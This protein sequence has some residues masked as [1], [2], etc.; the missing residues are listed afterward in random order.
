MDAYAAFRLRGYLP[1]LAGNFLSAFGLQMVAVAVSW[2]LYVQTRSALVLGNVGFVQ[3]A[4]FLFFALSAGHLADRLN[5][6]T[7]ILAG[8]VLQ[9][10][11]SLL[12]A[13]GPRSVAL[14]YA[15]LLLTATARA[16]QWPARSAILNQIVPP[17]AMGNAVTWNSSAMEIANMAGPAAA[18][19]LVALA[20]S[21]T[22]YA[23]QV[24]L[25]LLALACFSSLPGHLNPA[26]TT[27]DKGPQSVLDGIRF[28]RHNK[29]VLSAI[30]LDLFG[31][32][33]GGAVAL[34]PIFAADILHAGPQALG[35]LRAAP[36]AGA[37]LMATVQAHS[38]RIEHAGWA[39]L[40]TVSGFG[41]ATI[42]FAFSRRLWLSL[43]LLALLGAFDNVSVV[44]R[45]SLLQLRTPDHLR[46]RVFAATSIFI[47][48]SNQLGAVESG[49]AA[50]LFGG[51]AAGAVA[52]VWTGGV[53]TL[54]VV[55]GTAWVSPA[56]RNWRSSEKL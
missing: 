7:I 14:V 50:A 39:L 26:P 6:R 51:G 28:L 5:R 12:L 53:A 18:G 38:R 41:L 33:F 47:N 13:F 3:V 4:P 23:I 22:V 34:L 54:L 2:D 19:L 25:A 27:P 35:W 20:G 29:L 45:Q 31:V 42:G 21:R 56:L 1:L 52:S 55:A 40:A 48:C 24:G 36:S 43:L 32:L 16:F 15:C 10:A 17:D 37:V 49:W 30:S 44:L 8:Q 46:G 11:V 9:L